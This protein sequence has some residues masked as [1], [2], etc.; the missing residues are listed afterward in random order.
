MHYELHVWFTFRFYMYYEHHLIASVG[1][2]VLE[3][4]VAQHYN[5]GDGIFTEPH[6]GVVAIHHYIVGQ[7]HCAII[8]IKSD[9]RF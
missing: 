5:I 7:C 2:Q 6:T 8:G 1:N 4:Q 3:T 9:F